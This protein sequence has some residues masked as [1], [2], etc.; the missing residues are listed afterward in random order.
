[1]KR[2]L[3]WGLPAVLAVVGVTLIILG[4]REGNGG[5][6][7]S[8]PPIIE[9]SESAVAPSES[10]VAQASPSDAPSIAASATPQP[11]QTPLPAGT[12]AQQL[13]IPSVGINVLVQ[14]SQ[15]AATDNFPPRDTAYI[16]QGSAQPGQNTNSYI[17]AHA[18]E[19][20]FK[21]LWNVQVGAEVRVLM[22]DG[23]VLRYMVTEVRPNVP[24]PDPNADP[25]MDPPD[26]PLVLSL[27]EDCEE[28]I[29]WLQPTDH[30]RLTLQ[31]SQGF[32][33][34]WG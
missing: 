14:Q 22:S 9:P 10:A 32:N 25:A 2:F 26:P 31:T 1:M 18:T 27:H 11:P 33:R 24:C 19:A 13:E 7:T 23:S 17:F 30:E 8:L 6:T 4:T 28:G 21:P 16:L 12:V 29:F 3:A 15:D 34:N 5:P 20:L